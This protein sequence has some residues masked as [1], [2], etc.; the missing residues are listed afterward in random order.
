MQGYPLI[1]PGEPPETI[2]YE[3]SLLT[4]TPGWSAHCRQIEFTSS[5]FALHLLCF[6]NI[7]PQ[8]VL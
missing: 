8:S 3:P 4:Q 6:D 5:F 1:F 2:R 7:F